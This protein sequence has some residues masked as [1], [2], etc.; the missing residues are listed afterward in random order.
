MKTKLIGSQAN[1]ESLLKDV[2]N[3]FYSKTYYFKQ[4]DEN[5]YQ[6]FNSKGLNE[7]YIVKFEKK[8]YRFLLIIDKNNTWLI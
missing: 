8:R 5:T 1:L 7:N 4:I 6:V 2:N 3:Y